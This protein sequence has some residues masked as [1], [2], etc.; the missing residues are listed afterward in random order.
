MPCQHLGLAINWKIPCEALCH[1]PGDQRGC[2]HSAFDHPAWRRRLDDAALAGP[3]SVLGADGGD[4]A[5]DGWH[6]VERLAHV[7]ADLVHA[8]LTAGT[9]RAFRFDDV[10]DPGQMFGQSAD[11]APG[12]RLCPLWYRI[13]VGCWRHVNGAQVPQP[14]R[15]RQLLAAQTRSAPSPPGRAP[16]AASMGSHSG[17]ATPSLLEAP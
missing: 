6:D 14:A 11:V 5:Q 8:A 9:L 4:H 16:F 15:H 1:D 2:R 13:V 12:T 17:W 10:H 3:A 7:L